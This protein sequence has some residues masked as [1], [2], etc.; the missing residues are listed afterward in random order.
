MYQRQ[1][2]AVADSFATTDA[3]SGYK[4]PFL[5]PEGYVWRIDSFHVQAQTNYAAADTNYQTFY[6]ADASGNNIASVANGPATGGL[7]IGPAV[8][9]G[10]DETMTSTYQYID[11]TSAA[12]AIYAYT[13]AT[14][15]GLAML[16][17]KFVVLATP[18]RKALAAIS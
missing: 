11:C 1:F 15:G 9:T 14:G 13:A 12:A 10:I 8:A 18:R 4:Y 3:S 6:L 7:A 2:E 17:V 5:L 16:G